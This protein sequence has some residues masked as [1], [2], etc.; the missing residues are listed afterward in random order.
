MD[1]KPTKRGCGAVVVLLL[2]AVL[3]LSPVLYVLLVGPVVWLD[4]MD[5]IPASG[6]PALKAFYTPV[7]I[8]I[9]APVIGSP[10]MSYIEWWMPPADQMPHYSVAPMAP[11]PAQAPA[12]AVTVAPD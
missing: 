11:A 8:A 5:M 4:Q 6:G 10:I 3:L 12:P 7:A 1:E 9:D 2:V